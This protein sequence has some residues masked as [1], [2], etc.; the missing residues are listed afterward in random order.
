MEIYSFVAQE[1]NIKKPN[2]KNLF[3]ECG[4]VTE[5]IIYICICMCLNVYTYVY[6][7]SKSSISFLYFK[8]VF[9]ILELS[10]QVT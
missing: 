2:K 8:T 3:V 1:H 9:L 4:Y 6:A 10:T 7:Y 5:T